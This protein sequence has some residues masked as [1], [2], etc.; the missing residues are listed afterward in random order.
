LKKQLRY[1]HDDCPTNS[2][3]GEIYIADEHKMAVCPQKKAM[4]VLWYWE[5]E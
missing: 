2:D 3:A 5:R 1:V 4:S